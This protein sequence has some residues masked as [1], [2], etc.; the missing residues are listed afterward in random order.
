VLQ[1]QVINSIKKHTQ[2]TQDELDGYVIK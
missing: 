2:T 1:Y